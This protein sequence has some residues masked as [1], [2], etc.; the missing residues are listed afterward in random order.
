MSIIEEDILTDSFLRMLNDATAQKSGFKRT[1]ELVCRRDNMRMVIRK[2]DG[3]QHH[4]PHLHVEF[5]GLSASFDFDGNRLTDKP[6][7]KEA[8]ITKWIIGKKEC[9]MVIYNEMQKDA[10]NKAA[11]NEQKT[12]L[13]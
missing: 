10:P 3:V 7:P 1:A 13:L 12:S 9:L 11:I 5:T 4:K 6:V 2:E 8:K